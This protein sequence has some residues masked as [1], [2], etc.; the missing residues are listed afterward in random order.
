MVKK[1]LGAKDNRQM[2]HNLTGGKKSVTKQS[3]LQLLGTYSKVE[4]GD[5]TCHNSLRPN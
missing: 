1:I 4:W 2:L 3:Y 5:L